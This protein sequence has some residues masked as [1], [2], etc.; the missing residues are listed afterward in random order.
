MDDI[1]L[2]LQEMTTLTIQAHNGHVDTERW[3][4]CIAYLISVGCDALAESMDK[5]LRAYQEAADNLNQ[6][7]AKA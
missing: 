3:C 7:G 5:S 4:D 2:A 1:D 6:R